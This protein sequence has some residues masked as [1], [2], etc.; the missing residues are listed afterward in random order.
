MDRITPEEA[1]QLIDTQNIIIIDLRT[2]AEYSDGHIPKAININFYNPSF[3]SN[4]SQLD[5]EKEYIVYCL[6]GGR[7]SASMQL[8]A[9]QGF[10]KVHDL[11]GGIGAW[12]Q[13][14]FPIE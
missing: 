4:I 1:K 10:K 6:S 11:E 9:N 12:D 7:S 14:N 13:E 2:P 3:I 8:F 5:K